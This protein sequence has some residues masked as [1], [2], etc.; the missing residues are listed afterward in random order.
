MIGRCTNTRT[1][2]LGHF[3]RF[4][5]SIPVKAVMSCLPLCGGTL[6]IFARF[7]SFNASIGSAHR[8]TASSRDEFVPLCAVASRCMCST[9]SRVVRENAVAAFSTSPGMKHENAR[10]GLQSRSIGKEKG[11]QRKG[12]NH[13]RSLCN[14]FWRCHPHD[15]KQRRTRHERTPHQDKQHRHNWIPTE[16]KH[17]PTL[18]FVKKQISRLM[19]ISADVQGAYQNHTFCKLLA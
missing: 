6:K 5:S 13:L 3:S 11:P 9:M 2:F 19:V 8:G 18:P 17:E 14:N 4:S 7:F 1:C 10:R 16:Y 15:T 12:N